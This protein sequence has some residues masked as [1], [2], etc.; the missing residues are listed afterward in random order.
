[1]SFRAIANAAAISPASAL[2]PGVRPCGKRRNLVT[3]SVSEDGKSTHKG[4]K[5]F[6]RGLSR[7]LWQDATKMGLSPSARPQLNPRPRRRIPRA[8]SGQC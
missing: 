2:R 1:M 5:S 4:P 6:F 3:Q 8:N 7:F